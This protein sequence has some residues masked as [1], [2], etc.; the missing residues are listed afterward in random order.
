MSVAARIWTVRRAA[1]TLA[2][3]LVW[4]MGRL[5][6]PVGRGWVCGS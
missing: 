4:L 3:G 5:A 6:M 2:L 1:L